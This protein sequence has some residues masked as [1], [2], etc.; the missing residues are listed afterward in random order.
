MKPTPLIDT[1]FLEKLE[2]LAIQ[3]QKSFPGLV[4]GHK[5]RTSPDPARSFSI[6]ASSITATTCA[7]STGA[8]TCGWKSYS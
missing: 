1:V 6:I 7:P 3:W 4:G 2:R 8:H 5:F